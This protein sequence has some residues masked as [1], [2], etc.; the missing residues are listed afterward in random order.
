MTTATKP[1]R[2]FWA[3]AILA[4][5]WNLVGIFFWLMENFMMTE[6]MKASLPPE[7][8]EMM[9]SAPSWGVYVYGAAVLFGT[10]ASFLLLARKKVAVLLFLLSLLAILIQ[11]GYWIFVMDAVGV[12]GAEAIVMPLIVIAIGIFLYFYSKGAAKKGWLS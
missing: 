12:I 6:E 4:V 8:L 3:I 7:Q 9:N 10:L 11:M 5:I 1:N 2:A